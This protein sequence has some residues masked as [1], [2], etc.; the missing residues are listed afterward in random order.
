MSA[1]SSH[2]AVWRLVGVGAGLGIL[3][4]LLGL[5]LGVG[6]S[7]VS[8][9]VTL[10]DTS[11]DP[12]HVNPEELDADID[13][14]SLEQQLGAGI[15][16]ETERIVANLNADDYERAREQLGDE[17]YQALMEE[18]RT[19]ASDVGEEE[20]AELVDQ[21]LQDQRAY[22]EA[23]AAYW[24]YHQ[25]YELVVDELDADSGALPSAAADGLAHPWFDA[26]TPRML[27]RELEERFR[28]VNDSAESAIESYRTLA[29]VD[30]RNYEPHM[31]AIATSREDVT[32]THEEVRDE[33]FVPTSLTLSTDQADISPEQPLET[34][35]RL[36][37]NEA[38]VANELVTLAVGSQQLQVSTNATGWFDL[39]YWPTQIAPETEELSVRYRPAVTSTHHDDSHTLA[40]TVA[41]SEPAVS[42]AV[43]PETTGFGENISVTGQ[44]DTPGGNLTGLPYRVI[45]DGE[46]VGEENT[47]AGGKVDGEFP[48][49]PTVEQ[50]QQDIEIRFA[51][52]D[53]V[54]SSTVARTSLA[55]E[56][57]ESTL[58]FEAEP[59]DEGAVLV[60]G[61]LA[62]ADEDEFPQVTSGHVP[63]QSV[64]I[65]IEGTPVGTV[66]TDENGT[67][68]RQVAVPDAVDDEDLPVSVTA[69]FDGTGTNL[70]AADATSESDVTLGQSVALSLELVLLA[71][72]LVAVVGLAVLFIRLRSQHRNRLPVQRTADSAP[73]SVSYDE[74]MVAAPLERATEL[75][76][77]GRP[78]AAIRVGYGALRHSLTTDGS[79]HRQTHWEFYRTCHQHLDEEREA[80]LRYVTEC[81][82]QVAFAAESPDPELARDVLDAVRSFGEQQSDAPVDD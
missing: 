64:Q 53:T 4:L 37:A 22:V 13:L 24:E 72:G 10:D 46:L 82:E 32:E 16:G 9:P 68:E 41:Q 7:G 3:V 14:A 63:D 70:D 42:V 61:M 50:G 66:T 45:A 78:E 34:Q 75:L 48:L 17:Q 52:E 79:T 31:S 33:Q 35:G 19:V 65:A 12:S 21:A 57:R 71:A 15:A 2:V 39:T 27:A 26:E 18:Y 74:E 55:V 54:L 67:F 28:A 20:R 62:L 81:Y 38:P 60:R 80:T 40:V 23:M 30:D 11:R 76:E 59:G 29:E 44:L 36:V 77:A 47:T 58:S 6:V 25:Q 56:Q 8:N 73:A 43:D 49:P 51:L 1:D 5:T 69:T